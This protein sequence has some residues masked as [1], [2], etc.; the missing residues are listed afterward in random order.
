MF[1]FAK[2]L[3]GRE[4]EQGIKTKR[5]V[6]LSAKLLIIA[7]TLMKKQEAFDIKYLNQA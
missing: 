2:Q 1:Y 3:Q 4:K 7:W 6:K 5:W